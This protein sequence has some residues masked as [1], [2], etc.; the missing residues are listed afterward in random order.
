M[1]GNDGNPTSATLSTSA[2]KSAIPRLQKRINEL[3]TFDP[4]NCHDGGGA[5]LKVIGHAIDHTFIRIFGE[6]SIEYD[7]YS[8]ACRLDTTSGIIV[9]GAPREDHVSGIRNG[10]RNSIA[11]LQKI[12]ELF[13][14]E[15][16]F[17][18]PDAE[19]LEIK[20]VRKISSSTKKVFL[21]H[22]RD[23][24]PKETIARFLSEIGLQPVILHEQPNK[25]RTII[26]KFEDF[27]DVGFAVI[28]LTPDDVG[29]LSGGE[30]KPRAR[31]NVILEL[32]FFLGRFGRDKVCAIVVDGV[33]VPSDYSGVVFVPLDDTGGWRSKL[34]KELRAANLDID[35][36]RL[37]DM[38]A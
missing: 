7:R 3:Q 25:G 13:E 26:E 9:F 35:K 22:G 12:I 36:D 11:T 19:P 27:S 21:V 17:S 23:N 8:S 38:L 37:L 4:T 15:I 28:L 1:P 18:T 33:S 5:D 2:M 10:I 34:A 14:E 20:S 24:G 31:E 29:G 16:S 30:I 32:G 6:N